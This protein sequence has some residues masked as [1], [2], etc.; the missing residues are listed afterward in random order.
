MY[1]LVSHDFIPAIGSFLGMLSAALITKCAH[2]IDV[3]NSAVND[4]EKQEWAP[5]QQIPIIVQ[6]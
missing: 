1:E 3:G 4:G 5:V 2:S 6:L